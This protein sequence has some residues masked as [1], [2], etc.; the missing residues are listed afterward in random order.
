MAAIIAVA[1]AIACAVLASCGG[2]QT[3]DDSRPDSLAAALA[4]VDDSV[5]V[6]SPY[7]LKMIK[8]GMKNAT[9]SLDYYDWYLRL[10]RYSVSRD[11]PDTT[12][13]RWN[14]VYAFL[15][16]REQTPRVRGMLGFLYNIKGS[17]YYK[18]HFAPAKAIN[19]YNKACRQLAGS[20][21]ES[22][23]PNVCANLGDAYVAANDMPRAA[24][25]YRRALFLSDSLKLPDEDNV[26]LYMGLGRIYLNLGDF[27]SALGCYR[28]AD[29]N[30]R[31][32]SLNMQLYFL[33]NYG[34]YYY[35]SGDYRGAEAV[36]TRM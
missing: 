6:N 30:F 32:M 8:D 11:V 22:N 10:M 19:A 18:L 5:A 25:W 33:T 28:V 3:A 12:K 1:A 29:G 15:S 26:S 34:N 31:L 7:A 14:S 20:D 16:A 27:D 24:W 2:R 13:L 36:F 35:Y 4:N 23:L 21:C 9:D 17:Y